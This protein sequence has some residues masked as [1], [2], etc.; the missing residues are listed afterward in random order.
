MPLV[1]ISARPDGMRPIAVL[2][3]DTVEEA[4]DFLAGL[5]LRAP[6][7]FL[8]LSGED[9]GVALDLVG[10]RAAGVEPHGW[11]GGVV[12]TSLQV[13]Q[14]LVTLARVAGAGVRVPSAPVLASWLQ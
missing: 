7:A 6:V 11:R 1:F 9:F 5:V 2:R 3:S 8:D 14:G 13:L 4:L 10:Q 12:L